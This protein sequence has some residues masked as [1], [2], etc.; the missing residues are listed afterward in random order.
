MSLSTSLPRIIELLLLILLLVLRHLLFLL[1]L[2]HITFD[3][4]KEISDGSRNAGFAYAVFWTP[5]EN[6]DDVILA[7]SRRVFRGADEWTTR[8]SIAG[9]TPPRT[10]APRRALNDIGFE[11]NH[12]G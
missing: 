6:A 3:P 8:V 7:L 12:A 4:G 11:S 1:F 9:A 2:H 5:G 10:T